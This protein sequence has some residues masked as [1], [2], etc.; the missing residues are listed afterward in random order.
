MKMNILT[1]IA[2]IVYVLISMINRFVVYIP[3][4]IYLPILVV[5]LILCFIGIYKEYKKGK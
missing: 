2:L 3:D 4:Y 5:A 1:K